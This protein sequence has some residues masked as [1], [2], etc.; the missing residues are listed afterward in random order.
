[1]NDSEYLPGDDE[2]FAMMAEKKSTARKTVGVVLPV[3][4]A[5][6]LE[7]L[8]EL[9]FQCH[10]LIPIAGRGAAALVF[11]AATV[12][13][14]MTPIFGSIVAGYYFGLA[15]SRLWRYRHGRK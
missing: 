12:F 6:E 5:K 3:K 4:R 1:M 7:F 15:A 11:T 9:I 8:E 2:L 14:W 10:D 13:G